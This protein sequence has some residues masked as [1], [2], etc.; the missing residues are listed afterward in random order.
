MNTPIA[1]SLVVT[2]RYRYDSVRSQTNVEM[3]REKLA[4][5]TWLTSIVC[6]PMT[7]V[8]ASTAARSS[9]V[10]VAPDRRL[11][12]GEV[13]RVGDCGRRVQE[14]WEQI[15]RGVVRGEIPPLRSCRQI[16]PETCTMTGRHAPSRRGIVGRVTERVLAAELVGDLTIH[17]REV[18][19]RSLGKNARPPVSCAS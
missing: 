15:H 3:A 8:W 13:C 2:S 4:I 19:R 10:A 5:G 14:E 7:K 18:S 6:M 9:V 12:P 16:R 11:T 1:R 17:T